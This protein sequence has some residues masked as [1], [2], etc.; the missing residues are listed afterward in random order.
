MTTVYSV[1]EPTKHDWY[2]ATIQDLIGME[3]V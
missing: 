2:E 1:D 3:F